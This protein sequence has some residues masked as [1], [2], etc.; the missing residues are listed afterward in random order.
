MSEFKEGQEVK[1]ENKKAILDAWDKIKEMYPGRGFIDIPLGMG[2]DLVLR[3]NSQP[4]IVSNSLR[5]SYTDVVNEQ[6]SHVAVRNYEFEKDILFPNYIFVTGDSRTQPDYQS[7]G[8]GLGL[9]ALTTDVIKYE[10]IS[11]DEDFRGKTVISVEYDRAQ[12]QKG[13]PKERVGWTSA[14]LSMLGYTPF[15]ENGWYKVFQ[16]N[17]NHPVNKEVIGRLQRHSPPTIDGGSKLTP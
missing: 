2:N 9:F 11:H 3:F 17:P 5:R 8:L 12:A 14:N 10:L 7:L 16:E 6:G 13:T 1:D 4:R 15:E